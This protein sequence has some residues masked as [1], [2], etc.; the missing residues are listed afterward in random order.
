MSELTYDDLVGLNRRLVAHT[1]TIEAEA[2]HYTLTE[3]IDA[4]RMTRAMI[5][6]IATGWTQEQLLARPQ[7]AESD[8][9]ASGE[10]ASDR[11][12]ATETLTH[13]VATQNW[14]LL[15][16]D[17]LLH[18]R[19]EYAVMVRGLGDLARQEVSQAE[20]VAML[21]D[22]TRQ[23]IDTLENIPGDADLEAQRASVFFGDLSLRGWALLPVIHDLDHLAQIE[24]LTEQPSFPAA[25]A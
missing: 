16:I 9:L 22:A 19:R 11:W 17:R 1:T 12:S 24:R 14:Y 6:A 5:E 8:E 20:L 7:Q 3:L 10:D 4:L 15:H 21:Q 23:M 18:R 25:N 13:L 2:V